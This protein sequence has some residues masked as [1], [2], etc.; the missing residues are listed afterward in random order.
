[1]TTQLLS[2]GE[3]CKQRYD[4][5]PVE[6]ASANI[7]FYTYNSKMPNFELWHC[8]HKWALY[9]LA[10]QHLVIWYTPHHMRLTMVLVCHARWFSKRQMSGIGDGHLMAFLMQLSFKFPSPA[11]H[12]WHLIPVPKGQRL[13]AEC[14]QDFLHGGACYLCVQW[15]TTYI[16]QSSLTHI[17]RLGIT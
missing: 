16:L 3:F 6:S 12:T 7:S 13:K 15:R 17:C 11:H 14:Q 1:M 5:I 10:A 4:T 2:S 9:L 8:C